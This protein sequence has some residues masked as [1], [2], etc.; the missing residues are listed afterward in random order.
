MG[1]QFAQRFAYSTLISTSLMMATGCRQ[2][3]ESTVK[4]EQEVSGLRFDLVDLIAGLD[5]LKAQ[6]DI[7][8]KNVM[9]EDALELL[10]N[11][12]RS[13]EMFRNFTIVYNSSS[14]QEAS[15]ESPR[16]I[17]AADDGRLT[18]AIN[19]ELKQ[20]GYDQLEIIRTSPKSK[21]NSM[22]FIRFPYK[23]DD[24]TGL[25]S[26][27]QFCF[28][29]HG[30][31]SRHFWNDYPSWPGAIGS[32]DDLV[33]LSQAP[34][35]RKIDGCDSLT[36]QPKVQTIA[37][38]KLLMKFREM[39][40]ANGGHPRYKYFA[41]PV[42][43]GADTNSVK[44][45]SSIPKGYFADR[46][47]FRLGKMWHL[48]DV[49]QAAQKLKEWPSSQQAARYFLY[50]FA[51]CRDARPSQDVLN[52]FSIDDARWK[53][54]YSEEATKW[55]EKFPQAQLM[56]AKV[57]GRTG[58]TMRDIVPLPRN[59]DSKVNF[60]G[61][62]DG[63]TYT[64]N[65]LAW[66]QVQLLKSKGEDYSAAFADKAAGSCEL[67]RG[68]AFSEM[69]AQFG[70]GIA[71]NESARKAACDQLASKIVPAV[72]SV[73]VNRPATQTPPPAINP[74]TPPP[75]T[76]KPP[77]VTPPVASNPTT[78][79][80]SANNRP[81]P[82]CNVS[83]YK[84]NKYTTISVAERHMWCNFSGFSQKQ[85]LRYISIINEVNKFPELKLA[86]GTYLK[87]GIS[88][89]DD[90]CTDWIKMT[91]DHASYA[92]YQKASKKVLEVED[93]SLILRLATARLGNPWYTVN[94][95]QGGVEK[96]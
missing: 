13:A 87:F 93:Y 76:N 43:M 33:A 73:A 7:E 70:V 61:F 63:G 66:H 30:S 82:D 59:A 3:E 68:K 19:G 46:P 4:D 17:F 22:H 75:S 58:I 96:P 54:G 9:L 25:V 18:M 88:E 78:S 69:A 52:A 71:V 1:S 20:S 89:R 67:N 57:I 85:K 2:R 23:A 14:A 24:Q 16:I 40:N 72:S 64:I 10:S 34:L 79:T 65:L 39:A 38:N 51:K 91:Q 37:E 62:F 49:A 12:S 27:P 42:V 11:D 83:A 74:S 36:V 5:K 28:K 31:E 80:P 60:E 50:D 29:C 8:F 90:G 48:H 45:Y 77:V 41:S 26:N 6:R 35:T 53:S 15:P 56:M 55:Y 84:E 95:V 81:G 92:I 47:N 94:C 32:D 44:P 86:P 21:S